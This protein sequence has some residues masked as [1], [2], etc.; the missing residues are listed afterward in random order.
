MRAASV[1]VTR[2]GDRES[3]RARRGEAEGVSGRATDCDELGGETRVTRSS[4][5]PGPGRPRRSETPTWPAWRRRERRPD[6]LE[7]VSR[8]A[9]ARDA[10]AE[11]QDT[12]DTWLFRS[13]VGAGSDGELS[14][15]DSL[16]DASDGEPRQSSDTAKLGKPKPRA[17]NGEQHAGS[18]NGPTL[19]WKAQETARGSRDARHGRKSPVAVEGDLD[20]EKPPASSL[21]AKGPRLP[22][23]AGWLNADALSS[24][25]PRAKRKSVDQEA[26]GTVSVGRE[27]CGL[28]AKNGST[29][30]KDA[31]R[32]N[33]LRVPKDESSMNTH[34]YFSDAE[35][36]PRIYKRERLDHTGSGVD[37]TN[38]RTHRKAQ[39]A[40]RKE[41]Y[42]SAG[43][44]DELADRIQRK[45]DSASWNRP[46]LRKK[47]RRGWRLRFTP[48]SLPG[49]KPFRSLR[50][51]KQHK[52]PCYQ[53]QTPMTKSDVVGG[54][55]EDVDDLADRVQQKID[56]ER[57]AC[58]TPSA[59]SGMHLLT[60]PRND[61]DGIAEDKHIE[62][63]PQQP[64]T[65]TLSGNFANSC[66]F[67]DHIQRKMNT[68]H[69]NRQGDDSSTNGDTQ[70]DSNTDGDRVP[71]YKQPRQKRLPKLCLRDPIAAA[72][73][74]LNE[75]GKFAENFQQKVEDQGKN[76]GAAITPTSFAG[77]HLLFTPKGRFDNAFERKLQQWMP[78]TRPTDLP[79]YLKKLDDEN[80][81][82]DFR[83]NTGNE[84]GS[85]RQLKIVV[86]A[87]NGDR[88]NEDI[89]PS[90]PSYSRTPSTS[91]PSPTFHVAE[92]LTHLIVLA[93]TAMIHASVFTFSS[94]LRRVLSLESHPFGVILLV[95]WAVEGLARCIGGIVGDLVVD[96]VALLRRAAFVWSLAVILFVVDAVSVAMAAP[97][98]ITP[99]TSGLACAI[100]ITSFVFGFGAHGVVTPNLVALGAQ[101]AL[102]NLRNSPGFISVWTPKS[103]PPRQSDSIALT[104][105]YSEVSED[106]GE[107]ISNSM[108]EP[109]SQEEDV[110]SGNCPTSSSAIRAR[111]CVNRFYSASFIASTV[112]SSIVQIFF[113]LF[114][115]E[116]PAALSTSAISPSSSSSMSTESSSSLL[117]AVRPPLQVL[118]FLTVAGVFLIAMLGVFAYQSRLYRPPATNNLVIIEKE[119]SCPRH[120]VVARSFRAT[121]GT[122]RVIA[123]AVLAGCT[124][125]LIAGAAGAVIILIVLP[126]SSLAVR[127]SP[128]LVVAITWL[129]GM[130]I[131]SRLLKSVVVSQSPSSSDDDIGNDT[132]EPREKP[133]VNARMITWRAQSALALL[134]LGGALACAAFVRGQLYSTTVT[135]LCQTDLQLP[136]ALVGS[137]TVLIRPEAAGGAVGLCSVLLL[138]MLLHGNCLRRACGLPSA[139]KKKSWSF[140]MTFSSSAPATRMAMA[141]ALSLTGLF[142]ASVVEL[143]RRHAPSLAVDPARMPS[144]HCNK[145][146]VDLN[147]MWSMPS[148][149]VLGAADALF[150]VSLH[151]QVHVALLQCHDAGLCNKWAGR[152][153][154]AL[155]LAEALGNAAALSLVAALASWLL[156]PTPSDLTLAFLLLT[157]GLAL[158]FV[159][160]KGVGQRVACVAA[161]AIRRARFSDLERD[162]EVAMTPPPPPSS[163]SLQ[164][165]DDTVKRL[166][167]P[168]GG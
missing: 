137:A 127:V 47:S 6:E 38:D 98:A 142:L 29:D 146:I 150:R 8:M 78:A 129:V 82:P 59:L 12:R 97:E 101:S 68:A 39:R 77:K 124:T 118:V 61:D 66:D 156:G 71:I 70:C 19:D 93:S 13:T 139:I 40:I 46:R 144:R 164:L 165:S 45:I 85:P 89:E 91:L 86:D 76:S 121:H 74:T 100:L 64:H 159:M 147:V 79:C 108:A 136:S 7:R 158:T 48:P 37:W 162:I 135:Q 88:S 92:L 33:G 160:L 25:L 1:A 43:D 16:A 96:R 102:Y 24:H 126:H 32:S 120:G 130:A 9:S 62:S 15:A 51:S 54:Y 41:E 103:P 69:W 18:N 114:A 168:A 143:Y 2:A 119:A 50:L 104:R 30:R 131:A 151:E 56:R 111:T 134:T 27:G 109:D 105:I 155:A 117:A 21:P 3:A 154:G 141:A 148:L 112:G 128:F 110:P 152:V 138:V 153:L 122:A 149:I 95:S 57:L 75:A 99:A 113:F 36:S 81:H 140:S 94:S 63:K 31:W 52:R 4:S 166:A 72:S 26:W 161:T 14:D 133:P 163:P 167:M 44:R 73:S 55:F 145:P 10:D 87:S 67:A 22:R 49:L 157:T 23:I 42:E 11:A 20:E 83:D 116:L 5:L 60:T 125:V 80:C 58:T 84:L 34:R 123:G 115:E 106:A 53:P 90:D 107:R 17:S 28:R 65:T 132:P 35:E